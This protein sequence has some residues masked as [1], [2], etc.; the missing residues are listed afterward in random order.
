MEDI[1]ETSSKK[2]GINPTLSGITLNINGLNTTIKV[3]IVIMNF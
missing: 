1:Q 3:E 2:A